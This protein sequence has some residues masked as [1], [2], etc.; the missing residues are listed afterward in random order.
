M[1]AKD[2]QTNIRLPEE[3]KARLIDAAKA[4]KRSMGSEI[5]ARLAA[6]FDSHSQQ[7]VTARASADVEVALHELA[8]IA[9]VIGVDAQGGR[10]ATSLAEIIKELRAAH[11]ALAQSAAEAREMVSHIKS[12]LPPEARPQ[13]ESASETKE[14][15]GSVGGSERASRTAY[16]DYALHVLGVTGDERST[17]SE[18]MRRVFLNMARKERERA[19]WKTPAPRPNLKRTTLRRH[20]KK[21]P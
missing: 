6:S 3:L 20:V 7:S 11:D 9:N 8:E 15:G 21:R 1:S 2:V 19:G 4:N 13:P 14:H 10:P 17:E 18:E 12:Q 16:L 5:V